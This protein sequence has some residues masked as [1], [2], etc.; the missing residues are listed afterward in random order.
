MS[1]TSKSIYL[2]TK[3]LIL[4][5]IV[6]SQNRTN[7]KEGMWIPATLKAHEKD[8]RAMGL[9]IPVDVLYNENGTGLN[10]AVV[11]FGRGCTG[12]VISPLGLILTNH[13]CGYGS[14]QGLSSTEKDYFANGFFAKNMGEELP[15]GGLTVTFIRRMEN[16]TDRVLADIPDTLRDAS[17]DSIIAVRIA[18]LE[19]DFKAATHMDAMIKPYFKGNQYWVAIAETYRDIRLVGFPP[20]G[21]GAFGG[22]VENW[23]WPRHTGDFSM[24]RIYAGADN[25]PAEYAKDN[26]PYRAEQYFKINASGYKESNY[27]MVYG[28]PGTTDEYISS[29][30]LKQVYTLTDPVSITART[31]KLDVWTKHMGWSRETFLKYTSKRAGVANGW[32]K[33]QGE[34]KGLEMNNATEKKK[35]NEKAFQQWADTAKNY[36]YAKTLLKEMHDAAAVADPLILQ[37]QYNKEAVLGIELIAQAAVMEKIITCLRMDIPE[38]NLADTVRKLV[39]GMAGFY[40]NFDTATDKDV[41]ITLMALYF[42]KCSA[43]LP[44]YFKTDYRAHGQDIKKWAEDV[45]NNSMLASINKLYIFAAN[46]TNND[47]I[48]VLND[49]AWRLYNAIA[50][51]RKEKITPVLKDYNAHMRYLNR[52]Y[53]KA[54]IAMNKNKTFYPDA[55]LTL[56]VTYG[57]VKGL[58]PDGPPKYS[59]QTNLGEVVALDDSTS[60]IFMVP[61][62]LKELY[63]KKDFGRWG[64]NGTVPV[65]FVASNHTSGGN[66]G[67]PVLNGKGEL[68]GLNFDRAYEGTMSD[69]L[70]DPNR[71]RNISVD[72]RYILFI[73]E[74]FGDAGWLVDEMKIV[75]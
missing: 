53:M 51:E 7:A 24:F 50:T 74:K 73:V 31:R 55:N 46:V 59:F 9:E 14:V 32:K 26:K 17:R 69:Y 52:L 1:D 23:M 8:M 15:V 22:D 20:N 57:Q 18:K 10:N 11:L 41:F 45:Y 62:K 6:F 72:L 65:A 64:V 2:L 40:K 25:K 75:K 63:R 3:A 30:E 47:S 71:C 60:D 70:F 49:P 5:F 39:D 48:K 67:S 58:D 54:Q 34:V 13:H 42:T 44:E 21:I 56:R 28:F 29:F 68:I 38:T 61:K 66:S 33:W 43:S 36:P 12:E 16:V 37:D 19:K 27:T 35:Q 4:F